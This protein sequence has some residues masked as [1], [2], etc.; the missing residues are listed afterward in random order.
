MQATDL[1][2]GVVYK[3]DGQPL[4][5][6]KYEHTK[7]ARGGATVKVKTRNLLTGQFLEKG[8]KSASRLEDADV[9]RKNVQYLYFDGN[10]VFMDPNTYEQFS[11][12]E[13]LLGDNSKFLLEGELI[14]VMYFEGNPV[15]IEL[16][17]SMSFEISETVPG[18]KGNTVS[19]VL[20]EATLS[21]G[22]VVKVPTFIKI[23]DR[24]KIDTRTG[25]YLSKA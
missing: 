8:Y 21:N 17:N 25:E 9:Y 24:V 7:T 3:E 18:F 4:L 1:K 15:S 23:G 11:M 19:T 14:Q 10:Y 16:P 13:D 20:K 12:P 22:T 2:T 5:V 6:V